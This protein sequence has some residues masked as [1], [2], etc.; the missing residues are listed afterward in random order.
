L[1]TSDDI[2]IFGSVPTGRRLEGAPDRPAGRF[3]VLRPATDEL[4][5]ALRKRGVREIPEDKIER[6]EG[7]RYWTDTVNGEELELIRG[8]VDVVAPGESGCVAYAVRDNLIVPFKRRGDRGQ[9]T[10]VALGTI[11]GCLAMGKERA[12]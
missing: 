11:S 12:V 10:S 1:G 8:F 7:G 3:G 6:H 9:V 2:R 4:R 5:A